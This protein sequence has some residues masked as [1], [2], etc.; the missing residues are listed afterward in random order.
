MF[1]GPSDS[2]FSVIV[3]AALG[4]VFALGCVAGWLLF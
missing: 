1:D 3:F 2:Q 4:L